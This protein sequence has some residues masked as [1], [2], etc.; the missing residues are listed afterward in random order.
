MASPA[1]ELAQSATSATTAPE[2]GADRI[3]LTGIS[4]FGHHGVFDFERQN[5]QTFV[6]DVVCA[7]DLSE[8]G[9]SDDLE[10]TVD[11]GGLAAA[12]AADIEGEPL[13]LIEALAERI[14]RTC[15]AQ[16]RVTA[17]QVTVHKPQAPMPVPVGDVA[18]TLTRKKTR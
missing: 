8:A 3:A 13:N 6:V 15:L 4:A 2:A 5:G 16:P 7:I 10:T 11:Y 9:A 1:R 18:V 12:V 17:A 14:A